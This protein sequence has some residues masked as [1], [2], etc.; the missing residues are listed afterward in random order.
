MKS[1]PVTQFREKRLARHIIGVRSHPFLASFPRGFQRTANEIVLPI[2][3]EGNYLHCKRP[4][5]QRQIV[6]VAVG[7]TWSKESKNQD[8]LFH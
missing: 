8:S 6:I 1:Q 3:P 4:T 2:N 7:R 5:T